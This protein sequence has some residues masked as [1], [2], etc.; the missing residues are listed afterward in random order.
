MISW[1]PTHSKIA[2]VWG[3][4]LSSRS[5]ELQI[6]FG[7]PFGKLRV[8]QGFGIGLAPDRRLNFDSG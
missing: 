4:R 8:A 6:P 5:G 7:S 2:N 1:S 3:T